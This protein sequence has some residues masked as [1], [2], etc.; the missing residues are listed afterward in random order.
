MAN[1]PTT[2]AAL[3][4]RENRIELANQ[5]RDLLEKKQ[6]ALM[7]ELMEMADR[8]MH[9]TSEL[10]Q[11]AAAARESLAL[12]NALAGEQ[13][14]HSAALIARDELSLSIEWVNVMGVRVPHIDHEVPQRNPLERGYGPMG[15]PLAINDAA[16]AFEDEVAAI[17][18][19]IETEH[20]LRRLINEIQHTSRRLG[21]LEHVLIPRLKEERDQIEQTLNEREREDH[22]RLKLAK[23]H[24]ERDRG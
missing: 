2:R 20:R 19:L 9:E 10:E 15:T 3:L 14:V 12:A 23:E 24:L 17:L 18:D 21:A 7:E 13:A 1:V 6:A 5:G 11:A 4:D 8:V 22:L 16:Q